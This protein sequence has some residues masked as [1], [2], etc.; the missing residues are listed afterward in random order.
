MSTSLTA[1]PPAWLEAAAKLDKLS[2]DR[3]PL[4]AVRD[5]EPEGQRRNWKPSFRAKNQFV[6]QSDRWG[7]R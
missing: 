5:D 7:T 3:L 6:G 1:T 2:A 4:S